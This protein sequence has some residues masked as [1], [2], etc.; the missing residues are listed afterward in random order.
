MREKEFFYAPQRLPYGKSGNSGRHGK[1]MKEESD[2]RAAP[3]WKGRSAGR[4]SGRRAAVPF[5]L[6]GPTALTK[7][8]LRGAIWR[9]A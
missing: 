1:K 6:G 2:D 9:E 7:S 3:I 4:E 8:V 5:F